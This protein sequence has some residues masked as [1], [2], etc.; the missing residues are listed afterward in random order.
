MQILQLVL[1]QLDQGDWLASLDLQGAYFHVPGHPEVRRYMR[2]E[3]TSSRLFP[4]V[5]QQAPGYYQV[6]GPGD[7]SYPSQGDTHLSLS[8]WLFDHRQTDVSKVINHHSG[9]P[10][11]VG[12]L[13][14]LYHLYPVQR[15]Q[16][17]RLEI[18]TTLSATFLPETRPSNWFY[19]V[20]QI[21]QDVSETFG[22]DGCHSASSFI[23]QA[24]HE[25]HSTQAHF[26]TGDDVYKNT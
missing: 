11:A 8:G 17:L 5:C 14:N 12:V 2:Y 18:D 3:F 26:R 19:A 10:N 13:D 16:F 21:R 20:R 4:L 9:S 23:C 15:L 1:P 7:R 22:V 24:L 25:A 6:F